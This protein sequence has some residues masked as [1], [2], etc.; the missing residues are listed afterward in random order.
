MPPGRDGRT[1]APEGMACPGCGAA[2]AASQETILDE[3][4]GLPVTLAGVTVHRCLR[5]AHVETVIEGRIPLLCA[6]AG[7]LIHKR[8]RLAPEEIRFLRRALA[9]SRGELAGGL[10][11]TPTAVA[12][13][14]GGDEPISPPA[15]RR[16]RL[17]VVAEAT[18]DRSR[19][20]ALL[21][22]DLCL[23]RLVAVDDA[24]APARA[25]LRIAREPRGWC[26]D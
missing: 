7:A 21:R 11:T 17:M 10:G 2:M 26:V 3:V 24:A 19:L 12:R 4:A 14:E 9:L 20:G 16:L 25:P 8:V 5:C 18:T 13:W 6:I 15:D 23:E 1:A 22:G